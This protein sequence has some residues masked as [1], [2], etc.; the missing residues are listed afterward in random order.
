LELKQ[1]YDDVWEIYDGLALV[2]LENKYGYIDSTGT[3]VIPLEYD[4]LKYFD[5]NY[6]YAQK[7]RKCGVINKSG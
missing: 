5:G 7:N 4:D 3:L 1:Q 6:V 2:K